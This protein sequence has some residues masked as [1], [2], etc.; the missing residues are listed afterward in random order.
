M[1]TNCA[2]LAADLFLFCY[3]KDFMLSLFDKNQ[4][5]AIEVF[6]STSRYLD[7]GFYNDNPY[8][9]QMISQ[10]YATELQL[11]RHIP[12]I[13]QRTPLGEGLK[14]ILLAKSLP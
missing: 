5:D 7:G 12:L 1:G 8:F 9:E 6:N 13:L 10:I 11:K 14:L 3:G 4:T 2:S